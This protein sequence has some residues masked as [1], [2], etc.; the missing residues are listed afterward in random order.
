MRAAECWPG[1]PKLTPER[2]LVFC[3]AFGKTLSVIRSRVTP[4]GQEL[5]T[6]TTSRTLA[7]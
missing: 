4:E 1:K 7:C 6:N 3:P 2:T 5:L